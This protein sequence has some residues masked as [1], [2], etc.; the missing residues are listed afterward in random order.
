MN[1]RLAALLTL[2]GVMTAVLAGLAVREAFDRS[3]SSASR[4]LSRADRIQGGLD[5]LARLRSQVASIETRER[6]EQ[7]LIARVE[8]ALS[9]SGVPSRHFR[10]LVSEGDRPLGQATGYREQTVQ[11]TLAGL[12]PIQLGRFLE[13]W[14]QAQPTWSIE[15]IE[16]THEEAQEQVYDVRLVLAATYLA[17][18]VR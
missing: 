3:R 17:P 12:V 16:L 1:N 9:D 8:S 14:E 5:E 13:T 15:R 10:D 7:D 18:E 4:L 11:L 6:P 2:C